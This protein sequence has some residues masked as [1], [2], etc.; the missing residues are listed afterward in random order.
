MD[1]VQRA[2]IWV[3]LTTE[4]GLDAEARPSGA[5]TIAQLAEILAQMSDGAGS[6]KDVPST[7][8][9]VGAVPSRD[10]ESAC[11]LFLG[12]SDPIAQKDMEEFPCRRVLVLVGDGDTTAGKLKRRFLKRD[13]EMTTVKVSTL[14]G[15]MAMGDVSALLEGCDTVVYAAHRKL[16]DLPHKG[17]IMRRALQEA[18]TDLY[19]TFRA[20]VPTLKEQPIRLVFPVSMDGAFGVSSSGERLLG[21]FPSGFVRSLRRELPDCKFQLIDAGEISWA[22]AI[23]Q[24]IELMG[25]GLEIGMRPSGRVVSKLSVM[26]SSPEYRLPLDKGDL[27]IVTGGAR[28]IVFECVM[29]LARRTGCRLL[30]TGRTDLPMG[31]PD[32]LS[33]DSGDIDKVV[34][35]MEINLVK[36][37][38]LRL[39]EA[40][41]VGRKVRS[42]WELSRNLDRLEDAGIEARY[43]K[44]DVTDREAFGKL[45]RQIMSEDVVRA[46]IHGSGVQKAK[47]VTEL[48]DEA[49]AQTMDTK[50]TPVFTMMDELDW[51]T[52]KMFSGFGSIAGLFGNSGQTDY[53]LANDMLAWIV[54]G[55]GAAHPG[56]HAQTIE[57]TAWVGTGMVSE[58][59]SKRFEQ[60]GLTPV[61]VDEGVAFFMEGLTGS[62]HSRLAVFNKSAEFSEIRKIGEHPAAARPRVRLVDPADGDKGATA[63]FSLERDVYIS[64]HLVK[65]EPVVPG[66]FVTEIFAEAIDGEGVT[67][68][69]IQFR[70]PLQL[71]GDELEVEIIRKDDF[72]MLV[73]AQRPALGDK[74]LANLA[75]ST[76]RLVQCDLLDD[77]GLVI[78]KKDFKSLREEGSS[79]GASFYN[80][81]D[82][83]F[84]G[85]LKTGP[86]FRGLRAAMEKG[87]MFYS[88]VTI[89]DEAAALLEVPGEFVFNP[90]LADMAVQ[91]AAAWA[92][93]RHDV[94]EIPFEIGA[95]HVA[96]DLSGRDAV[97]ICRAL[98][99]TAEQS[100]MDLAVRDLD[101]NL[102]LGMERLVLKSIAPREED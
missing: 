60:A 17:E 12:G 70:R 1:S 42:Q 37:D 16:L 67:P 39:P 48:T 87:D 101:G 76:C 66:T 83:K 5:R 11:G 91:V 102:I 79:T 95:L 100:V 9:T 57:W 24:N 81:L 97:V 41:R 53:A 3:S 21:A 14:S 46:V 15:Q 52:I 99:I 92:M 80:M 56:L 93:I 43:E 63:N 13:I 6:D 59:E 58:E 94:M 74:G 82:S 71:R 36:Q 89:T 98:E 25:P 31:R 27:A 96:R 34:R 22:D 10:D 40:K 47:P 54:T 77:E 28:G 18:T 84:S 26:S 55:L 32:W 44:C 20:L 33:T 38:G 7:K 19:Q 51:T 23:D 88:T 4:H 35:D 45:L 50:L 85:A 8:A 2:E 73:P 90:V 75:Y 69:D 30:L 64:Q 86:V 65:M 62:A 61:K 49:I 78:S 29:E 68:T 72:M